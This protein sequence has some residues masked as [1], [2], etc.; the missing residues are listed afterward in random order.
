MMKKILFLVVTT[1]LLTHAQSK[2]QVTMQL[3]EKGTTNGIPAGEKVVVFTPKGT[4]SLNT[5]ENTSPEWLPMC[6]IPG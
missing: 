5:K 1:S 6:R 2:I 4:D 3:V